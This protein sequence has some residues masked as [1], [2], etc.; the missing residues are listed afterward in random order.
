[1]KNKLA[2]LNYIYDSKKIMESIGVA[3]DSLS[4]MEYKIENIELVIPVVGGF[5][6]GKSSL[7]NSFLDREILPTAITPE[8]ALATE[9][10]YSIEEYVEAVDAHGAVKK[11]QIEEIND[12]KNNAK[13][14][15]YLRIFLNNERLEAICPLILVDMPGFDSPIENH[16]KAIFSYLERGV[17][18]VFLTS[19]EDGNISNSMKREIEN[20]QRF[21]KGFSFCISKTNLRQDSDVGNVKENIIEQLNGFFDY[22]QEVVLLDQNGGNNLDR[23]L[24]AIDPNSLY[25]LL[26][27]EDLRSNYIDL[28]QSINTRLA[29]FKNTKEEADKAVATLHKAISDIAQK[30]ESAIAEVESRYSSGSVGVIADKVSQSLMMSKEHLIDMALQNQEV[31]S[32]EVNELVKSSLLANTQ[33]QLSKIGSH[34]VQDISFGIQSGFSAN[35]IVDEGFIGKVAATTESFLNSASSGLTGLSN[36]LKERSD[37]TGKVGYRSLA[38]IFAITT[39]LVNPIL[40]VIIVFLPDIISFFTKAQKEKNARNEIERKIVNQ[41]IPE[42]RNKIKEV[43][44]VEIKKQVSYLI[45]EVSQQFEYQIVI[46]QQEI[47]IAAEEKKQIA[48]ERDKDIEELE[49]AKAQLS[50]IANKYLFNA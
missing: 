29:T 37:K 36:S 14:L 12:L 15:Q 34:I 1:M 18:F 22:K 32:R 17:H 28:E 41:I 16:N 48:S 44:P 50:N 45:E 23:I 39:S 26:F 43:L 4:E 2:Y 11:Y 35:M 6:A 27:L 42:V 31:F 40:E 47:N 20:I 3:T 19:I 24:K 38:T 46:K 30:K 13:N 33:E 10:H 25:E 9:I 21:G 5:S 7:I 49:S 8:T